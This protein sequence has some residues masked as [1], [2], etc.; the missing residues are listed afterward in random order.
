LRSLGHQIRGF[1]LAEGGDVLNAAAVDRAARGVEAIVHVAGIAGDRPGAPDSIMAVNVLGTW[2]VLL[3]AEAARVA[4][5]VHLSSGKALGLLERDPDYLPVDDDHRGLPSLP[6]ALSKWLAEEMCE[7]FTARTGIETLCLRPVQVFDA[8]GYAAAAREPDWRPGTGSH[9]HL[10]VHIDARDVATACAAAL[11]CPRVGHQ[12]LLLSAP[13][14]ASSRP[15]R[16]LVATY[17]PRVE[18]RVGTEYESDPY[19]S[20]VDIR[21]AQRVLGWT[22][23]HT[24]PGRT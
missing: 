21:R 9:W 22:P 2:H 24:W 17:L 5:V 3:A 20:L 11:S 23:R 13:D 16:E 12:R 14:I 6:Y 1:D 10:G 18:W 7:A 4:R 8:E 19:R 15:T